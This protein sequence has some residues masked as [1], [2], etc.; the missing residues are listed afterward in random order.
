MSPPP[1]PRTVRVQAG[2]AASGFRCGEAA[3]DGFFQRHAT[4]NDDR[5][6]GRTYVLKRPPDAPGPL[7]EVL[8]FYTLS[9]TA[10]SAQLVAQST[11]EQ[12]PKYPIPAALIGRLASDERTGPAGWGDA[13]LRRLRAGAGGGGERR[14]F[15]RGGRREE[16]GVGEF[17]SEV[18]LRHH[19]R[20]PLAA[21]DVRGLGHGATHLRRGVTDRT[22]GRGSQSTVTQRSTLG[23]HQPRVPPPKQT[24]SLSNHPCSEQVASSRRLPAL[25]SSQP[26][27]IAARLLPT[28]L[29]CARRSS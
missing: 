24:P 19:R 2:D 21:K 29:S 7:P 22:I 1:T 9:M 20:Q 6:I 14:V 3:L 10:I 27:G 8:G 11:L 15:R 5:G 13:P 26:I 17:L 28:L 25:A 16:R 18:R 4:S 23:D 12:L